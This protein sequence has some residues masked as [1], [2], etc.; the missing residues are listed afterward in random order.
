MADI[1]AERMTSNT[2]LYVI[3]HNPESEV[4]EKPI[5]V[6][7]TGSLEGRLRAIQNGNPRRIAYALTLA[8]PREAAQYIERAFH[9]IQAEHRLSGEWFDIEPMLGMQL[10]CLYFD[11]AVHSMVGERHPEIADRIREES[12]LNAYMKSFAEASK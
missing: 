9:T 3:A 4:F 8:M 2:Y 5:K 10:V 11:M 1:I 7:I 12:G 6:G